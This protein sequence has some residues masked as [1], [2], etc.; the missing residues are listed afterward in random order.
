MAP[1]LYARCLIRFASWVVPARARAQWRSQWDSVLENGWILLQRGQLLEDDRTWLIACSRSAWSDALKTRTALVR[2]PGFLLASSACVLLL[3]GIVSH[4]FR[5]TRS[6]FR[7]L[8]IQD[9]S[10]LVGLRY[11]G[12]VG[13]P[14]GVPPGLVPL[15]AKKSPMLAGIAGYWHRPYSLRSRVT[16]NFFDLLGT[17]PARGRLFQPGDRDTVVL[18]DYTWRTVYRADPDILGKKIAVRDSDFTVIGILPDSFWAVSPEVGVWTPMQLEPQPDSELPFLIGAI[19]RIKPGVPLPDLRSNLLRTALAANRVLPRPPEVFTPRLPAARLPGYLFGIAFA[20]AVGVFLVTRQQAV[21]IRYGWPYWRFLSVK[22]LLLVAVPSLLWIE[23]GRLI[24]IQAS[25]L[26][27]LLFLGCISVAFWWS[28]ADQ[29]R[30][31]PEC[32]ELLAMPVTIGSWSSVLNPVS[33]EFLCESGHG[34][35][36]VPETE[37]SERDRWTVLDSSWRHLFDKALPR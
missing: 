35:L 18:G 24:P 29:R 19:A 10:H 28:F 5:E 36:C 4:G 9:P 16:T 7:P 37:Q 33:T 34:A 15:W 22:T 21:A 20:F 23:S 12:S 17:H 8:P 11:T 6:L 14:A 3:L 25:W 2:S 13:Q 30:R 32:L 31:C 27:T 26:S 1:P